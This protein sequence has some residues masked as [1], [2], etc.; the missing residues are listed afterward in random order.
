ML[1]DKRAAIFVQHRVTL[2]EKHEIA[3]A[4][5]MAGPI[6]LDL[7]GGNRR[8][9]A[10]A[11]HHVAARQQRAD[12]GVAQLGPIPR[13]HGDHFVAIARIALRER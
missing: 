7:V 8:I 5:P 2:A 6:E 10:G 12:G 4:A 1:V 13:C 11:R 9:E 3:G